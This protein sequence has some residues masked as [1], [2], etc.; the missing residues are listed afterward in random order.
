M[1]Q[2]QHLINENQRLQINNRQKNILLTISA[3]LLY[4]VTTSGEVR[5]NS[6]SSLS[7]SDMVGLSLLRL[8]N[9]N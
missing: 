1:Y 5:S 7:S 2:Q 3:A 4:L 9:S 8:Q 6:F